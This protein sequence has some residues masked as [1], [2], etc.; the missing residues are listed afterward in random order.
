MIH[1]TIILSSF[2]LASF[3]RWLAGLSLWKCPH[4]NCTFKVPRAT[5]ESMIHPVL[6]AHMMRH[7]ERKQ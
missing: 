4:P 5:P 6:S 7:P 2:M 3:L 1:V